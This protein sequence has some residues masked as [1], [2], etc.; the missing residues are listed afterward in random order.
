MKG[1]RLSKGFVR[2]ALLL[3]LAVGLIILDGKPAYTQPVIKLTLSHKA[4]PLP[5]LSGKAFDNW[6]KR[7]EK[8]ANGRVA[9]TIYPGGT[10]ISAKDE[11][12]ALVGGVAD[13]GVIGLQVDPQRLRLNN[14][15]SSV[16][17]LSFPS[18]QARYQVWQELFN[19]FPEIQKELKGLKVLFMYAQA[20]NSLQ[21]VK[22]IAA[23]SPADIKGIRIASPPSFFPIL[24]AWGAIEVDIPYSDR[25]MALEKGTIDGSSLPMGMVGSLRIFEVVKAVAMNLGAQ[26]QVTSFVAFNEKT[27]NRLPPDIQKVFTDNNEYGMLEITKAIDAEEKEGLDK[28]IKAGLTIVTATPE[29]YNLWTKP[30]LPLQDK[31]VA[32]TEAKGL[33]GKRVVEETKRL[34]GKYAK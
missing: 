14:I 5:S 2:C 19:K 18:I 12:D 10:L 22:K 30:L 31:W 9:I 16:P 33:P 29:E 1:Q 6:A 11:I 8:Q 28:A 34:L 3:I 20:P 21:F 13:I 27:W 17:G 24:R 4:P 32:E 25:Y 15:V 23:H 26:P 7:I